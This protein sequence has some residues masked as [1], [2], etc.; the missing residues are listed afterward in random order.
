MNI[1]GGV[2]LENVRVPSQNV[3]IPI[4][5][6]EKYFFLANWGCNPPVH[7]V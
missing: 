7:G 2:N 6:S 1:G 5:D 3:G 4:R